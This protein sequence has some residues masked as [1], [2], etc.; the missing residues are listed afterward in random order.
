MEPN[1]IVP[2]D[3]E[4]RRVSHS[5]GWQLSSWNPDKNS[6]VQT[7]HPPIPPPAP[8]SFSVVSQPNPPF[9]DD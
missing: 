9:T 6:L 3:K 4:G 5:G 7:K 1:V 2:E 8:P